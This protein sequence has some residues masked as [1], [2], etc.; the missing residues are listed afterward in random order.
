M[1]ATATTPYEFKPHERPFLPGS[2]ATPDHPM[3]RRIAYAAIGV[4]LGLTG[5]LSNGLLLANLPQIQRPDSVKPVAAL[6]KT[7]SGKVIKQAVRYE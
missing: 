5:G 6:P 7:A 3:G 2:P 4:L 1:P